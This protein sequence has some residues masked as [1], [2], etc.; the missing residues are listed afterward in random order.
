LFATSKEDL[1]RFSYDPE[2]QI[3]KVL[4][5]T[6]P[7]H[8]AFYLFMNYRFPLKI[9]WLTQEESEHIHTHST[10]HEQEL[11]GR[12]RTSCGE[13]YRVLNKLPDAVVEFGDFEVEV[14]VPRIVVAVGFSE[15]YGDLVNDMR[16]WLTKD[17]WPLSLVILVKIEENT[18]G[19]QA[20]KNS[21]S[22]KS[23]F[24]HLAM[25][26][27]DEYAFANANIDGDGIDELS[28]SME[29][30]WSDIVTSD[31]VGEMRVFL[32]L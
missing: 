18:I 2:H 22:F 19:L 28:F 13:R 20:H 10:A 31:W 15:S 26:H 12:I 3:L 25:R 23:T 1:R 24:R 16:Q 9:H 30:L 32:E 5:T 8:D 7:I 11:G 4:A 14:P 6:R 27:G 21:A 29:A 17:N